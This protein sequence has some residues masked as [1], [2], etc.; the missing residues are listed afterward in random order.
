MLSTE[1]EQ[2]SFHAYWIYFWCESTSV[3]RAVSVA[4]LEKWVIAA[5]WHLP[6]AH[7]GA[8]KRS[9]HWFCC[10]QCLFY[11]M[12]WGTAFTT[13]PA[14][15]TETFAQGGRQDSQME[16]AG[17][18]KPR[19]WFWR[20]KEVR[21][22][23]VPSNRSGSPDPFLTWLCRC[24]TLHCWLPGAISLCR[25]QQN[26]TMFCHSHPLL[27]WCCRLCRSNNPWTDAEWC[28]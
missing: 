12:V 11:T 6:P 25:T 1:E 28:Y 3:S 14:L 24:S 23:M 19:V 13:S 18:G 26:L 16:S 27:L 22:Q 20:W 8:P 7:L 15:S 10:Q 17:H 5:T 9:S 21:E 4:G 2:E